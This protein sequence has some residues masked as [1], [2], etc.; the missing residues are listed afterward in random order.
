MGKNLIRRFA[1]LI[2]SGAFRLH[3]DSKTFPVDTSIRFIQGASFGTSP[4]TWFGCLEGFHQVSAT[5]SA[6]QDPLGCGRSMPSP[7]IAVT[8]PCEAAGKASRALEGGYSA[9][10]S[11]E[12]FIYLFNK[13]FSIIH[14]AWA[15]SHQPS[16][17]N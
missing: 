3:L 10:T 14:Y 11:G 6:G 8:E 5:S 4:R 17:N 13:S 2:Q 12:S 16:R 7:W 15:Y 9:H 1:D